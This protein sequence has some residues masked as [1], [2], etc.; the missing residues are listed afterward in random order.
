MNFRPTIVRTSPPGEKRSVKR[1]EFELALEVSRA[2]GRPL[3]DAVRETAE[4]A[5]G[6]LVLLLPTPRDPKAIAVVRLLDNGVSSFVQV[7]AGAAPAGGPLLEIS[8]ESEMDRNVLG[9]ARASVDVLE[10]IRSHRSQAAARR[11]AL[12]AH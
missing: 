2:G 5:G 9:L 3:W 10:R 11:A 6:D 7:K 1:L 8:G 12:A 4:A